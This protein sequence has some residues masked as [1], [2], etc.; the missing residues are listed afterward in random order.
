MKYEFRQR[1]GAVATVPEGA[2]W[3]T[4]Q[5]S[6]LATVLFCA[7][8]V[9]R[10]RR[11]SRMAGCAGWWGPMWRAIRTC[12]CRWQCYFLVFGLSSVGATMPIM[13]GAVL[14]LVINIRRLHLAVGMRKGEPRL[15]EKI[16]NGRA[17]LKNGATNAI[18]KKYH[19]M[20][21]PKRC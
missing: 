18:Y 5:L 12:R 3:T 19:H 8:R 14:A 2:A 20:D 10:R 7:G 9:V 21:L 17:N 16:D 1:T 13:V 6:F 11:G 15:K 4:V